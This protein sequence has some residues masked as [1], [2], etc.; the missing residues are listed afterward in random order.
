MIADYQFEIQYSE[1]VNLNQK[2]VLAVVIP[3]VYLASGSIMKAIEI[4][5]RAEVLSYPVYPMKKEF[6]YHAI[7]TAVHEFYRQEGIL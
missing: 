4:D 6:H 2:N 3:E 7:Y 5:L 1:A